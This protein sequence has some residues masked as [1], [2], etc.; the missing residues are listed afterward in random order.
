MIFIAIAD[1]PKSLR[2]FET[3]FSIFH[4]LMKS[5]STAGG[6]LRRSYPEGR[7]AGRLAGAGADQY[8]L[9]C[10]CASV[11]PSKIDPL[12]QTGPITAIHVKIWIVAKN[13]I[14][15]SNSVKR[16]KAGSRSGLGEGFRDHAK[17]A[18]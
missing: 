17:V 14:T 11:R 12:R 15:A 8:E 18:V 16:Q 3:T 10:I 9:L 4:G 2:G 6:Q 5:H 1:C 13:L 7:E